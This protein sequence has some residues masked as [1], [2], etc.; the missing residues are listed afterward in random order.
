MKGISSSFELEIVKKS[1]EKLCLWNSGTPVRNAV[2]EVIGSLSV[3]SDIT[4]KK[5][6]EQK[7]IA[8]NKELSTFVH[9]VS[10]DLKG[11][12]STTKSLLKVATSELQFPVALEYCSLMDKS[13][14]KLDDIVSDLAGIAF[15]KDGKLDHK[16]INFKDIIEDI[17]EEFRFIDNFKKLK[18]VV[19]VKLSNNYYSDPRLL[20]VIFRNLI[21]NAIRYLDPTK[22]KPSLQLKITESKDQVKLSVKDNGLGIPPKYHKQIFDLYFRASNSPESTG[23]GLYIVKTAVEKLQGTVNLDS[24]VGAGTTISI[25]LPKC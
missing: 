17:N 25:L 19:G 4:S 10:H 12:I 9:K 5:L 14:K 23:L 2:G 8:I 1:G 6:A 20:N 15:I 16:I 7:L 24:V 3:M 11:P 21:Q 22:T 18:V 13:I